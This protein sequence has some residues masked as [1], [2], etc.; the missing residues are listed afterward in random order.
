MSNKTITRAELDALYDSW[1]LDCPAY[2]RFG[3]YWINKNPDVDAQ[4]IFHEPNTDKA[5][6]MIYNRFVTS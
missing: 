4:D 1:K 3:Q 5:Y 2:I 6:V